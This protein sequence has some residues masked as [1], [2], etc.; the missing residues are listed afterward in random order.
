MSCLG[1][2]AEIQYSS[3]EQIQDVG[4]DGNVVK[5]LAKEY[6]A[7]KNRMMRN[8]VFEPTS[9]TL[10]MTFIINIITSFPHSCYTNTFQKLLLTAT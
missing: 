9:P 3:E 8:L 6:T 4:I 7:Y 1:F 10:G 2:H 5:N